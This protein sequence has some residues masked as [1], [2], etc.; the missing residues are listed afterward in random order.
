MTAERW[1]Q[2]GITIEFLAVVRTLAE[3]FRVRHFLG[4]AAALSG[5][6]HYLR[7]AL[8]AALFCW[9]SLILFFLRRFTSAALLTLI[10]VA[11]LL[12]YKIVLMR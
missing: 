6:D 4:D 10:M 7:G 9:A 5:V 8:I 2:I 12:A 3:Y 1:A 11:M